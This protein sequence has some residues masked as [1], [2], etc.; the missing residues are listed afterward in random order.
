MIKL[1][2][3]PHRALSYLRRIAGKPKQYKSFV[4]SCSLS[5]SFDDEIDYL[6]E[7]VCP[8]DSEDEPS[9]FSDEN[10]DDYYLEQHLSRSKFDFVDELQAHGYHRRK[11]SHKKINAKCQIKSKHAKS[12]KIKSHNEHLY[13]HHRL[14]KRISLDPPREHYIPSSPPVR[15]YSLEE[16]RSI[17]QQHRGTFSSSYRH[18]RSMNNHHH[19]EESPINVAVYQAYTLNEFNIPDEPTYD[20]MM[21][22]FLLDMQNRD[23]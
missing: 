16:L 4:S 17:I 7:F 12:I 19:K 23:L 3:L 21:I 6:T 1:S 9:Y 2:Y 14:A 15:L 10:N 22:N 18:L 11:R 13:I 5:F 8:T 20:D